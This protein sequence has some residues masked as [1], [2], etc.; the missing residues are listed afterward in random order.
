MKLVITCKPYSH[1]LIA[2]SVFHEVSSP[3]LPFSRETESCFTFSMEISWGKCSLQNWK[4]NVTV[5]KL[6]FVLDF[7][8]PHLLFIFLL[9]YSGSWL[10]FFLALFYNLPFPLFFILLPPISFIP[11][12][13]LKNFLSR[14]FLLMYDQ[15]I[16]LI[17]TH[18]FWCVFIICPCKTLLPL[19]SFTC[20][21]IFSTPVFYPLT[22]WLQKYLYP[23]TN[24]QFFQFS[25]TNFKVFHFCDRELM[26]RWVELNPK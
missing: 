9:F 23:L 3:A 20:K 17:D 15:A 25:T 26:G 8:S 4:L 10:L 14:C 22:K 18:S 2:D 12:R 21:Y 24:F 1:C 7:V 16:S 11:P 19:S 13:V 6:L 5:W